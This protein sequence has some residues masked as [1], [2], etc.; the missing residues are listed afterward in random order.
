VRVCPRC[1]STYASESEFCGIDGERLVDQSVDALIGERIDRYEFVE[2]LGSGAVGVVYRARHTQLGRDFAIKVLY[3]EFG[4]DKQLVARFRREAQAVSQMN[5][6]NIIAVVDFGTT[7]QGLNFLVMEHL[8]GRTLSDL[9]ATEKKLSPVRAARIAIQIAAG[10]SEAHRLGFVHRDVKPANVMMIGPPE[11]ELAKILDFGIVGLADTSDI[12]TKLTATGRI[13]GTPRYMSPEQARTSAVGPAADLYSLGII[14]YELLSGEVPFPGEALA[15]V[16]VMHS[17]MPPAPLASARGLEELT[18]RLLKKEP[19]QRPTSAQEVISEIERL[20]PELAIQAADES[21][22]ERPRPARIRPTSTPGVRPISSNKN[23]PIE[24][25]ST[26][27]GNAD[28][29]EHEL[30]PIPPVADDDSDTPAFRAEPALR[31]ARRGKG[32]SLYDATPPPLRAHDPTKPRPTSGFD[33]PGSAAMRALS[34]TEGAPIATAFSTLGGSDQFVVSDA[35]TRPIVKAGLYFAGAFGAVAA[36]FLGIMALRNEPPPSAR[37]EALVA[38]SKVVP[39]D[40][41]EE[42]ATATVAAQAAAPS[43]A[44]APNKVATEPKTSEQSPAELEV[45][46]GHTLAQRGLTLA[47]L[48]LI[49][50]TRKLAKRWMATDRSQSPAATSQL[51]GELIAATKTAP[52]TGA[53]LKQKL[54]RVQGNL[55]TAGKQLAAKD[56]VAY[57]KRLKVI[58]VRA[59][60]R[61]TQALFSQLNE[62]ERDLA[63]QR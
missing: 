19:D 36:L 24:I 7:E 49:P 32:A 38:E 20:F 18:L 37:D 35:P 50:N 53:V 41:K 31:Q 25:V 23:A 30:L 5:H 8:H 10:L 15:D 40:A 3:G 61:P 63:G 2:R 33:V 54:A 52:L 22:T 58:A 29:S 46:L 42:P 62:I 59:R 13:V 4:A 26:P 60:K 28:P 14:L 51:L 6:P 9:I 17:T 39:L 34:V 45:L 57:E 1:R 55:R 11:E 48:E 12:D 47:D 44:S 56:R 43:P 27:P 21:P 16:L